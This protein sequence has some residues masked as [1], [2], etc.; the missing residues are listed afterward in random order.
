LCFKEIQHVC[1]GFFAFTFCILLVLCILDPYVGEDG[2]QGAMASIPIIGDI[3]FKKGNIVYKLVGAGDDP[4]SGTALFMLALQCACCCTA[5]C[6]IKHHKAGGNIE[7]ELAAAND[8]EANEVE[9]DVLKVEESLAEQGGIGD[10]KKAEEGDGK[11]NVFE[12]ME[13]FIE[14]EGKDDLAADLEGGASVED[15]GDVVETVMSA[16]TPVSAHSAVSVHSAVSEVSEGSA[17]SEV[18]EGSD[19]DYESPV[20]PESADDEEDEDEEEEA[21]VEHHAAHHAAHHEAA[22]EAASSGEKAVV[23]DQGADGHFRV[24]MRFS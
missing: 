21:P 18:S 23:V 19:A 15:A 2:I 1:C 8:A 12:E 3:A 7:D 20:T 10:I 17:V 11:G 13:E 5:F 16:H 24:A 6:L 4:S 14:A 9:G 22:E